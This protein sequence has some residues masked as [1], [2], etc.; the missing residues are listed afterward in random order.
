MATI[1]TVTLTFTLSACTSDRQVIGKRQVNGIY[2]V[3]CRT[4]FRTVN[5]KKEAI[6]VHQTVTKREYDKTKTGDDC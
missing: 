1:L 6:I 5:G 4:G 3:D 2:Y